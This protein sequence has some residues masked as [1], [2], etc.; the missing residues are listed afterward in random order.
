MLIRNM[1]IIKK[2]IRKQIKLETAIS[3][4]DLSS[5]GA[6]MEFESMNVSLKGYYKFSINITTI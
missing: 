1:M 4:L 3:S 2:V 5:S 6:C